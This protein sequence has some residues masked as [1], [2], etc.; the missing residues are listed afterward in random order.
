[1]Q[2]FQ[3]KIVSGTNEILNQKLQEVNPEANYDT[4]VKKDLTI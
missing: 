2:V 3:V 1:M 4:V